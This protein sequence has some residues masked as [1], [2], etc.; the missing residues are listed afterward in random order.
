MQIEEMF[1]QVPWGLIWPIL[2]IELILKIVAFVDLS[3][4]RATNGPVIL[5]VFIIL[6]INT[7]GP[8]LY[9][10]VGRRNE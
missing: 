4:R 9:F 6:L 5:W 8:I 10:T 1:T 3:K 2:L 7:I